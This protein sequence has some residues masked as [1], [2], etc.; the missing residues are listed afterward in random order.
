M[1]QLDDLKGSI[2]VRAQA[3]CEEMSLELVEL[4]L[5]PYN[6]ILNVQV[7]A[8]RPTGGIGIEEC[9]QLNRRLDDILYNELK[10]GEKYTLEVSSPGLDRPAKGFQGFRRVI[11]RDMQIFLRERFEGKMELRGIV[12][13]V[14]EA[15]II[16]ETKN[17]ELTVPMDK[18][19]KGKQ[20]II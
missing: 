13:G 8:D 15:D 2:L 3:L 14:R 9:S 1:G 10:L 17:G 19:D 6:E 7:F 20:V 5:N 16:L 18:I 12:K 4:N 11:G